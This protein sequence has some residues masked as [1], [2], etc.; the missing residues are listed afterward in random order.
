MKVRYKVMRPICIYDMMR[1]I[2]LLINTD[3]I[4]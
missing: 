1:L 3:L 2:S 4:M